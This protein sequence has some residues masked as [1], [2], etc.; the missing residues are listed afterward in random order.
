MSRHQGKPAHAAYYPAE[1]RPVNE[2]LDLDPSGTYETPLLAE[3]GGFV[4]CTQGGPHE[5]PEGGKWE[6]AW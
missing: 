6:M 5:V 1:G 3:V 4:E 2:T